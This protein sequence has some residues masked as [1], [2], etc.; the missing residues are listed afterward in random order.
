MDGTLTIAI[1]DFDE[2]RKE[3]GLKNAPILEQIALL[4]PF[5]Q[6]IILQKLHEIELKISMK[7]I[8][9]DGALEILTFL[10]SKKLKL[11]ILTRNTQ[12]SI[13][14]TFKAIQLDGFFED[15]FLI[16]REFVPHKPS[17]AGIIHLMKLWNA[18]PENTVMVGDFRYDLEAGKDAG[19][20]TIYV[21][22]S[23]EFPYKNLADLQITSLTELLEL[24][25]K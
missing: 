17:G 9:S 1:H 19:C 6:E 8:R 13:T 25:Q 18:K 24:L 10:K 2:I 22:K 23:G 16:G 15:E 7:N 21:D 3:L 12:A 4:P 14:E 5:K 11:G 20:R